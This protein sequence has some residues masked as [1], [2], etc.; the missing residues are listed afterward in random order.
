MATIGDRR[1][2]ISSL[3]RPGGSVAMEHHEKAG[4]F[5][6]TYRDRLGCSTRI[7]ASFDI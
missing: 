4:I 3:T 2:T 6:Q 1:N 5:W 7:D